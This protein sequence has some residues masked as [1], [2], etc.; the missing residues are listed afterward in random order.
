MYYIKSSRNYYYKIYK[1]NKKIRISKDE[2]EKNILK[3]GQSGLRLSPVT[4]TETFN[5]L[6]VNELNN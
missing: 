2:Y 6:N 4:I 5:Q 1:N 3:G